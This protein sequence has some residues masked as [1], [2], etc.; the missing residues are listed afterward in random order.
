M[1]VSILSYIADGEEIIARCGNSTSSQ[2]PPSEYKVTEK[3]VK[4][5]IKI[6]K[7]MRLSSVFDFPTVVY[8]VEDA[9]RSFTHQHV[10]HRMGAHMQQSFRYVKLSPELKEEPWF[11]IPPDMVEHGKEAVVNYIDNQLETAETYNRLVEKG[12]K[13]EDARFS[14]PIGTKTFV[15]TAMDA[16]SLLHYTDVR[17][18][19]DAQWEIRSAANAL[20]TGMRFVYPNIFEGSGPSCVT[21]NICRGRGKMVCKKDVVELTEQLED[22]ITKNHE[23][24]DSLEVNERLRLDLTDYLG[25]RADRK[26][27]EEVGK[28]FD[29]DRINLGH[30]VKLEV[31][32]RSC[33]LR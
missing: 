17:T 20:R 10:R 19:R 3:D 14:L 4:G 25:Y 6:A 16:E 22:V 12:V 21:D 31:A 32:K 8:S 2:T 23:K 29:L 30:E 27:E 9:S 33:W 18:C 15:S 24:F 7:K 28:E 1:K 5:F 13:P 11:V 26:L